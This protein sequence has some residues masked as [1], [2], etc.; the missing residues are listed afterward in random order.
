MN[1]PFKHEVFDVIY[2][3]GVLHHNPDTRE[4]LRAIAKS[5]APAGRIY[6]WV[7]RHVPGPSCG[8]L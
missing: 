5:L 3:S 7:Y 4:A 8:R 2:S 6:I 1:P